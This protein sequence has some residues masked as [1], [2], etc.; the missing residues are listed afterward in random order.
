MTWHKWLYFHRWPVAALVT[1]AAVMFG[2]LTDGHMPL[3]AKGLPL[4]LVALWFVIEASL[5]ALIHLGV[6]MHRKIKRN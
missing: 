6:N 4:I 5:V 2:A 3:W 1:L